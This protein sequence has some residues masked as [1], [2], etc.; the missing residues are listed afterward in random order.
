M[1]NWTLILVAAAVSYCLRF[2]PVLI[3]RKLKVSGDGDVYVFL[4]YAACAVTGGI[5]YSI[6]F[7]NALFDSWAGH[8]ESDQ[9]VKMM[10]ILLSFFVAAFTRSVIKSLI[11]CASI[12]A[13]VL[14]L[15]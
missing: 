9:A 11:G 15:L 1:N 3:F 6:A 10:V 12:Y 2:L 14:Y 4:S 5:I 8:F 13:G 7:G